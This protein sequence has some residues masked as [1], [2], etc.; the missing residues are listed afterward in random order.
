MNYATQESVRATLTQ[1]EMGTEQVRWNEVAA[2]I[3][4]G[5]RDEAREIVERWMREDAKG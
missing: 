4:Y 1:G 2:L 3:E 5:A